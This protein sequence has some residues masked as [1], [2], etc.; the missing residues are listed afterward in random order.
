MDRKQTSPSRRGTR[1]VDDDNA[2]VHDRNP[3]PLTI[4]Q[5]I[6]KLVEHAQKQL[7]EP[8]TH[9][10]Q[11]IPK[12]VQRAQDKP[13][14]AGNSPLPS[15]EEQLRMY[16]RRMIMKIFEP[17]RTASDPKAY[18]RDPER[19]ENIKMFWEIIQK[20]V[21]IPW[22]V[23]EGKCSQDEEGQT[24]QPQDQD[25]WFFLILGT[26]ATQDAYAR[27]RATLQGER[28]TKE[29]KFML[30]ASLGY[31]KCIASRCFNLFRLVSVSCQNARCI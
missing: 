16:V 26:I 1:G 19:A 14:E 11:N 25:F 9:A 4:D 31:I 28:D 12:L 13:Q 23:K 10:S 7:H 27:A 30:D 29:R 3:A 22:K 5:K 21:L 2:S 8:E 24:W 17:S 6:A 15:H 18:Y 20:R